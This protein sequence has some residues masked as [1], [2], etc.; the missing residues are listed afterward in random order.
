MHYRR[1]TYEEYIKD[2]V[3]DTNNFQMTHVSGFIGGWL[4]NLSRPSGIEPNFEASIEA[5]EKFFNMLE[6]R[7]YTEFV[8]KSRAYAD[9]IRQVEEIYVRN[10]KPL[11]KDHYAL[12]EDDKPAQKKHHWAPVSNLYRKLANN[13]N[14]FQGR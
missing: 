3:V 11:E 2:W 12:D 8:D 10:F 14:R 4:P 13:Y 7:G 6:E 1:P 5:R 9:I